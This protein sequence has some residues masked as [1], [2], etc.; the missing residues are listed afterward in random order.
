MAHVAE[1]QVDPEIARL[2][3]SIALAQ[4]FR[5]YLL[6]TAPARVQPI[7]A[8]L[9]RDVAAV[10]EEPVHAF[11]IDPYRAPLDYPAAV[12][13]R[14]L[15]ERILAPLT[16]PTPAFAARDAILV[17]DVTAAPAEDDTS[18]HV[19]FERMNE[20]RDLVARALSGALVLALSPRLESVFVEAAPDFWS[21]RSL[22]VVA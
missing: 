10:R 21:I 18:F 1:P 12:P 5:F 14:L 2:V 19:L 20:R 7:A 9:E 15:A 8:N 22:A 6:V 11:R 16:E 4:G 3:R 17:V 13:W